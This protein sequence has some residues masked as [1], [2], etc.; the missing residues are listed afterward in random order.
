MN[1]I[2]KLA[3]AEAKKERA[4][5]AFQNASRAWKNVQADFLLA[6]GWQRIW[7]WPAWER[8]WKRGDRMYTTFA[9][10]QE[11]AKIDKRKARKRV[12]KPVKPL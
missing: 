9:A 2:E 12:A 7:T 11:Q 10:M 4:W 5:E 3:K 8:L 6:H 1:L